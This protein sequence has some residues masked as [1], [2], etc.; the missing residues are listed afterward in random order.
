MA[1][2]QLNR[3]QS[4]MD[5]N[6]PSGANTTTYT[7]DAASNLVT[8]AYPNHVTSTLSYDTLNRVTDLTVQG[9]SQSGNYHYTLNP[10][11]TRSNASEPSGRSMTWSY[12][13]IYR[14]TNEA[15]SSDPNG[16]N[17]S[18]GYTPD[19]VGNRL[20]ASSSLSGVSSGTFS[21]DADDRLTTETYDVNGNATAIGGGLT[22]WCQ[23]LSADF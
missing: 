5:N 22:E 7:Y 14:L 15:I 2:D 16:P 19:P 1:S 20:S 4:V 6:L 21:Y 17:G 13:G 12:D 10:T 23:A 3:L 9:S 18:V 8:V 11:G